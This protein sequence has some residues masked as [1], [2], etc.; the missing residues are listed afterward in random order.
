M[1]IG[2][3]VR[4]LSKV[5]RMSTLSTQQEN[6]YLN[7]PTFFVYPKSV[8]IILIVAVDY[9]FVS[10]AWQA[11]IM[12]I[13]FKLNFM[14]AV[15][16]LWAM[17]TMLSF[18]MWFIVRLAWIKN[19]LDKNKCFWICLVGTFI[20]QA[21]LVVMVEVFEKPKTIVPTEKVKITISSNIPKDSIEL[22]VRPINE[23]HSTDLP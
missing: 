2:K 18:S 3:G 19:T 14:I 1:E 23:T 20:I 12:Q 10:V 8:K 16:I 6:L 21:L 4:D 17:L 9:V 15:Y 11:L 13:L 7:A 5:Q 22:V